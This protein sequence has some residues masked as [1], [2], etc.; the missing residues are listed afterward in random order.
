VRRVR[1][2][3]AAAV[4]AL[5]IAGC[6]EQVPDVGDLPPAGPAISQSAPPGPTSEDAA[7]VR[8]LRRLGRVHAPPGSVVV[9]DVTGEDLIAPRELEFASDATL[10]HLRWTGWGS[11]VAT[12]RGAVSLPDCTPS[13]AHGL[14]RR[15]P[16]TIRLTRLQSCAGRRFYDAAEVTV[17]AGAQR[18]FAR[19]F[20][21]APC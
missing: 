13:C 7:L 5:A 10:S 4:A 20:I 15:S 19:A 17:G 21:G 1:T 12:G 18:S 14:R 2:S 16:A 9:V 11:D 6:G 3:A 8:R